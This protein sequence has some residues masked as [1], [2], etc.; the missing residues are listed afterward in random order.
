MLH[1]HKP[2]NHPW[3]SA[4][5]NYGPQLFEGLT[6]P[7][8]HEIDPYEIET[9]ASLA[10]INWLNALTQD[11]HIIYYGAG[12]GLWAAHLASCA[13]CV[14]IQDRNPVFT[15]HALQTAKA[16]KRNVEAASATK[17][18]HTST[19]LID[20]RREPDITK[21]LT[22][23]PERIVVFGKMVLE[24]ALALLNA[25]YRHATEHNQAVVFERDTTRRH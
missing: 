24:T 3:W 11:K 18:C 22:T 5:S 14:E 13:K 16:N 9:H 6:L 19:V 17:S 4:V 21:A 7:F 20:L 15:H 23:E 12:L 1:D 2:L 25:G 8:S 10:E